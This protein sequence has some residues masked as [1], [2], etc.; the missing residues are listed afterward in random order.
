MKQVIFVISLILI[1]GVCNAA[2]WSSEL[3]VEKVFTEGK[4]DI[5]VIYTSG[6]SRL[7]DG[8]SVNNWSFTADTESRRNRAYST[9]MSALLSGKTILLWRTD[10]CAEWEYHEATAVM[11]VK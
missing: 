8:C 1:S 4:S 9:L 3:V 5:V 7:T 10:S 11:L 2:E 6:Q